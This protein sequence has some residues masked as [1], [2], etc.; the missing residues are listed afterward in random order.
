MVVKNQK[1]QEIDLVL[2]LG[3][4]RKMQFNFSFSNGGWV[5]CRC[6]YSDRNGNCMATPGG[7]GLVGFLTAELR[8]VLGE[9]Q[10]INVISLARWVDEAVG[11]C[12]KPRDKVL[13]TIM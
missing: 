9:L 3:V 5:Y 11:L 6:G 13:L 12:Q 1:S 7:L 10:A 8:S 2:D 4:G